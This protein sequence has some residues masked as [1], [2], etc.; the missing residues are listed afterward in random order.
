MMIRI[1]YTKLIIRT[2]LISFYIL[3][4]TLAL[5]GL[6]KVFTY[7]NT[8]ADKNLMLHTKIYETPHYQ[9]TL[10]WNNTKV[11]GRTISNSNLKLVEK[12]YLNSWYVKQLAFEKNTTKGLE[13]YFTKNALTQ[14]K[15]YIDFNTNN[16]ITIESTTL[17]HHPEINLFSEDGQLIELTDYDVTEVKR[18]F[19]NKQ[20]ILETSETNTYQ[21]ILLLEDGFW[22]TRQILKIKPTVHHKE[23][24]PPIPVDT[25]IKGINYY[26]QETPWDMFGTKFNPTIIHKDFELLKDAGINTLRIFIQYQDFGASEVRPEKLKKLKKVLDIAHQNNLKTIVTLFDF[27]GDYSVSDWTLNNQHALHI[28]NALK[29]HPT[30]FAW[31]IKNEPNLDFESR[32]KSTILAWLKQMITY[33]KSIDSKHPVTI[34]WSNTQSAS[35]LADRLDFVSF[36]YYEKLQELPQK[37]A[38]LKNKIP[39]KTIVIGEFGLS[40]YRGIWNVFGNSEEDQAQYHKRFQEIA[41]KHHIPFMAWTLYDFKKIP[42]EVVGKLPWRKYHQKHF[43]FINQKGKRKKSFEYLVMP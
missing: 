33:V 11:K 4:I 17:N 13:N 20:L 35:I 43:G 1:H 2:V 5:V 25:T 29:E 37:Y 32:G 12:D 23:S 7:L 27:Y 40:S 19:K 36:H 15:K 16:A 39:N 3:L 6:S 42:K 28:V 31:D 24:F 10:Q 41:K 22:K 21:Y 9:P 26:P 14:L 18:V 38:Q 34:G 8:G 30:L